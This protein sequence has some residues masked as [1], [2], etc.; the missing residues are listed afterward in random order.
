MVSN[1][2]G[3][4]VAGTAVAHLDNSGKYATSFSIVK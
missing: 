2:E 3:N 4:V 1:K